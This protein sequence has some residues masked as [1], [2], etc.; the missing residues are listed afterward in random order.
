MFTRHG[1]LTKRSVPSRPKV[2][3]RACP[4][5]ALGNRGN[6][7]HRLTFLVSSSF[8]LQL[9]IHLHIH[10]H[11]HMQMQACMCKH[12][13]GYTPL[14]H[15]RHSWTGAAPHGIAS[16]TN[17]GISP[18]PGPSHS[19]LKD[20]PPSLAVY[21][22]QRTL[23]VSLSGLADGPEA[24]TATRL[25]IHLAMRCSSPASLTDLSRH[26]SR[27]IAYSGRDWI[28]QTIQTRHSQRPQPG[29]R[30]PSIH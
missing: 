30:R 28:S 4:V 16:A 15:A 25:P 21:A 18:G 23:K 12:M 1:R 22:R 27:R 10:I 8:L 20:Q 11:I 29:C 6:E 26:A 3:K 17:P 2:E 19:T 13:F 14:R 7:E 5:L 9:Y 24:A